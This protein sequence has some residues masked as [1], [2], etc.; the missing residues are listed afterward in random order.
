MT[1]SALLLLTLLALLA[2]AAPAHAADSFVGVATEGPAVRFTS[3]APSTL[4]GPDAVLGLDE[5]DRVLAMGPGLALGRSGR[6]YRMDAPRLRVTPTPAVVALQGD[7]FSLVP[8]P[9]AAQARVLSDTGQDVFVD[10]ASGAVTPGPG[11]RSTAGE[12]LRPAVGLARDG[13]LV[14]VVAGRPALYVETAPGS[15]VMEERRLRLR[16]RVAFPNRLSLAVAGN[17][18]YVVTGFP[19]QLR[20]RQSQF[21]SIDLSTLEVRG[22]AGPYFPREIRTVVWTGSVPDDETAPRVRVLSAPRT[23]SLRRLR[24][25]DYRVRLRCSEACSVFVATGVGGRSNAGSGATRVKTD[26]FTVRL[27]PHALR[28]LRL[29]RLGRARANLR[30][31]AGDFAGNAR[32]IRLRVRIVR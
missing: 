24:T 3:Q 4:L 30:I 7:S 29:L 28:E 32:T 20:R 18:A 14:G 8:D 9:A 25:G 5:G 6:L 23:L 19:E 21:L 31:Y 17:A 27:A 13:R 12:A 22:E 11:L 26:P 10:L 2:A 1:R 16:D 15:S